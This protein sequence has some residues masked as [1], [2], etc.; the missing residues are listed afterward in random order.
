MT[1]IEILSRFQHLFILFILITLHCIFARAKTAKIN[2]K[3][4]MFIVIFCAILNVLS[5]NEFH[6]KFTFGLAFHYSSRKTF[7]N[8]KVNQPGD[9]DRLPGLTHEGCCALYRILATLTHLLFM[10]T[11]IFVRLDLGANFPTTMHCH[12]VA[13]FTLTLTFIPGSNIFLIVTLLLQF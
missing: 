9:T 12:T 11:F 8:R 1:K 4:F 7:F 13:V 6:S 3:L 10:V 5:G 2:S